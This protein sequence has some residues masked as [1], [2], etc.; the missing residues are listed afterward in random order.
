MSDEQKQKGY[1][2]QKGHQGKQSIIACDFVPHIRFLGHG[3]PLAIRRCLDQHTERLAPHFHRMQTI[4]QRSRQRQNCSRI[5]LPGRVVAFCKMLDD[6]VG[7]F[8]AGLGAS[9]ASK[10]GWREVLTIK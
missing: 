2:D 7:I 6:D 8:I 10:I 1:Q 4:G 3:D 9:I 5:A